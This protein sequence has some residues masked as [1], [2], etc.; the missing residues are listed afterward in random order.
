M[1]YY[2]LCAAV[3]AFTYCLNMT[4]I[5]IF[6]H[7]GFTHDAVRINPSFQRFIISSGSWITGI[8]LKA[9]ACMHRM[10]HVYSDTDK[11]PHSPKRWGLFG[12]MLGQ[13]H[14]YNS[15]LR[16]LI[17]NKPEYTSVVKDL[18]FDVSFLNRHKLWYLPYV[19]HVA[20]WLTCG[21]AFNAW[22]L[23]YAYFIGMMSHPV[24]GWLVNAFGH[25]FG[26][27]N[28]QVDD[29]SRNNTLVAWLCFGEGFQNNHHRYPKS[30]KFAVRWF[31]FD[32]GWHVTRLL[33]SLGLVEI[34]SAAKT[35]DPSQA[36]FT[37]A[38]AN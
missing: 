29:D 18:N 15:T 31:E 21:F 35:I 8:D 1:N 37:D 9:W 19:V 14:S 6:Y 24:Q 17:K 26:Y 32:F 13:L 11:D 33:A 5:S 22:L 25:A 16:G 4:Y 12:T 34:L 7:R 3:F 27:R 10:H 20:V 2:W 28:F 23:G 36:D 38:M 30:A